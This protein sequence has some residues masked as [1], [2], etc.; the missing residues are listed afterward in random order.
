MVGADVAL[1]RTLEKALVSAFPAALREDGESLAQVFERTMPTSFPVLGTSSSYVYRF[2]P[3]TDSFQRVDV[4]LG[5]I[6]SERAETVGPHKLSIGASY[7]LSLYDTINGDAL[8]ALVSNDSTQ[9]DDHMIICDGAVCEPV[10]GVADI[11]LAARIVTVSATYGVTPNLDVNVQLPIVITSLRAATSFSGPDPRAPDDVHYSPY[12][13][14]GYANERSAGV[15][16][17]LLRLK[18]MLARR[19]PVNVAAGLALSLPT[20]NKSNFQGT[21]D[22]LVSPAL[23]A[24]GLYLDRVEPHVN[25]GF[26]VDADKFDRSQVRYSLG[27]D[28]RVLAWLTL[29]NDF[30][31]I[32]DVARPDTVA[33]PV[34]VQIERADVFQWSTGFKLAPPWRE[35]LRT[36]PFFRD[37]PARGSGLPWVWFFDVLLPLNRDGLRSDHVFTF[38]AEAVF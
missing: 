19:A 35:A 21:G 22:T 24:S 31:G 9:T 13:D 8:D 37:I 7:F 27:A 36:V 20:G 11:D 33:N 23:Y 12:Q 30:L 10:R 4:P 3:A 18:Y 16:D 15:G 1:A 25:L 26:V 5:P 17:L 2:D 34:F 14:T 38:G 29:N 32:S 6:F 28:V